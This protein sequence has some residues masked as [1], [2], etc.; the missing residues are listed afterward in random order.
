[1][2]SIA[3]LLEKKDTLMERNW[4]DGRL[5]QRSLYIASAVVQAK[6]IEEAES[7]LEENKY[8]IVVKHPGVT[9]LSKGVG[10]YRLT[11]ICLIS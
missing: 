2:K 5:S 8:K 9:F 1:M 3:F 11:E 7:K 4:P 6:D 10:F